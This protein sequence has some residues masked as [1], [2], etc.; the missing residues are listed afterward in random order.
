MLDYSLE[1]IELKIVRVSGVRD[2]II[3]EEQSLHLLTIIYEKS[4]ATPIINNQFRSVTLAIIL[5]LYQG[6][7]DAVKVLLE[8]LTIPGE[9]S[10]RF[11]MHNESHSMVLVR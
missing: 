4:H 10:I 2:I 1:N 7:Q 9:C 6:I 5:W 11:I 8:N 3:L